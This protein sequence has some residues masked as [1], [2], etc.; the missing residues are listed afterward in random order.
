VGDE[1]EA[2][3]LWQGWPVQTIARVDEVSVPPG[4]RPVHARGTGG[5]GQGLTLVHFSTQPEQF[6]TQNTP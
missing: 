1:V 4:S 3:T 2:G 5:A 6:L